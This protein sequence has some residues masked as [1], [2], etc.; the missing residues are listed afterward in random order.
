MS[1]DRKYT[2]NQ[3]Y[4][5]GNTV[6]KLEAAPD[7]RR[8]AERRRERERQEELSRRKRVA[9]RNQEHALRMSRGY[10]VF[11]TVAVLVSGVFAGTYIKLQSDITSRMKSIASL[12]SQ[13]SDTKADNDALQKRINT[14]ADLNSVKDIAM[15]QLG[16]TYATPDQI[17]YYTVD[18]EDY[19]NQYSDIP[20][21]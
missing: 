4:V 18:K 8:E 1:K 7:S 3:F 12:E 10:V 16:M 6:R 20:N 14:S 17:I 21:N 9:R 15:N 13:I 5:D 2:Q 19:M 11:L